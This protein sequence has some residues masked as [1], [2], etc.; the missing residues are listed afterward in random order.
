MVG[1]GLPFGS[2]GSLLSACFSSR[3]GQ[4]GVRTELIKAR[5]IVLDNRWALD[6]SL[7]MVMRALHASVWI[8]VLDHPWRP[9]LNLLR[10]DDQ[11]HE[12]RG[13]DGQAH[14]KHHVVCCS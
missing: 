1:V 4:R 8:K 7:M 12:E 9:S 13:H 2:S 14:V 11:A 10:G 3:G 6:P 5:A